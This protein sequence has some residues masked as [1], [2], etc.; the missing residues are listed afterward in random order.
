MNRRSWG[1]VA[2]LRLAVLALGRGPHRTGIRAVWRSGLP[3]VDR[4]SASACHRAP[5]PW[6]PHRT[7]REPNAVRDGRGDGSWQID[8]TGAGRGVAGGVADIASDVVRELDRLSARRSRRSARSPGAARRAR[9]ADARIAD[10][11]PSRHAAPA[12]RGEASR[13]DSV[14][15]SAEERGARAAGRS[16]SCRACAFARAVARRRR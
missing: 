16:W 4:P 10:L 5:N 9:R 11:R 15:S 2:G 12:G 3:S 7:A 13:D 8:R 6:R 1:A 14:G